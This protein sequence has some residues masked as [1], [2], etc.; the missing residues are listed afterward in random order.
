MLSLLC[1]VLVFG[2]VILS[3]HVEA[4]S[5][6][7]FP[8]GSEIGKLAGN[9]SVGPFGQ[10]EDAGIYEGHCHDLSRFEICLGYLKQFIDHEGQMHPASD[11]AKATFCSQ[12]LLS[13]MGVSY[14]IGD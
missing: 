8:R 6:S 5:F 4:E 9:C 14:T 7:S 13:G 1:R 3:L 10:V 12:I 2:F 11:S